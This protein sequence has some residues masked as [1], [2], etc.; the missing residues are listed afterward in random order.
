MSMARITTTN[1]QSDTFFSVY[2]LGRWHR[3]HNPRSGG[4]TAPHSVQLVE[5]VSIPWRLLLGVY[6]FF[7]RPD[8]SGRLA[9]ESAFSKKEDGRSV[10]WNL[11]EAMEQS[12]GQIHKA[13]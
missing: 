7:E 5:A 12:P 8:R 2:H 1:R 13:L 11:A 6:Q 3:G 4:M 9:L 10:G